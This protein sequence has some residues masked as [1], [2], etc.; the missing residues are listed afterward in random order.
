MPSNV[1]HYAT[2]ETKMKQTIVKSS[3][4]LQAPLWNLFLLLAASVGITIICLLLGLGM[5][6]IELFYDYFRHP[7]LFLLNWIPVL[8]V[9]LLLY[10]VFNRQWVSFLLNALVFILASIGD[11]YKLKFRSEPFLYSDL[12]SVSTAFGVADSY[13]LTPNT[14]ILLGIV[15]ILLGTSVI[16]LLGR[17]SLRTRTRLVLVL[18]ILL[19]VFPVWK[20]VYSNK[21]LYNSQAVS[22]DHTIP[23]WTQQ[24]QVSKVKF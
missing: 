23:G 8:A 12:S 24:Y 13:D 21:E 15:C 5:M 3:R 1:T 17:R 22:S 20:M 16:A 11:F 4:I 6:D 14:R 10:A 7:L 19:S 2:M 9:E 18:C